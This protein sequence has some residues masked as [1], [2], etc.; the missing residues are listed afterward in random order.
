MLKNDTKINKAETMNVA[1]KIN[2]SNPRLVKEDVPP[3]QDLAKPVPLDCINIMTT[4]I[5]AKSICNIKNI[6]FI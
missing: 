5:I 4:R 1:L 2:F 6:F 3:P